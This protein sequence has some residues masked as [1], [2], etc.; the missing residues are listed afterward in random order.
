MRSSDSMSSLLAGWSF[1]DGP[2]FCRDVDA[3]RTPG[4][5]PAAAGAAQGSELCLPRAQLVR[6]P[7]A[8]AGAHGLPPAA[9]MNVRVVDAEAGIPAP[10]ARG[11][12]AREIGGVLH[13][14]AEAGRADQGAVGASQAARGHVVPV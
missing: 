6:Q 14:A 7:L 2:R 4:D 8:V 11:L 5:A 3:R 9:A 12:A 1:P 10:A 13:R